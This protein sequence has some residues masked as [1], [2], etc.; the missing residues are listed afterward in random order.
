MKKRAIL[1][2]LP[3]ILFFATYGAVQWKRELVWRQ[4]WS[5]EVSYGDFCY[6]FHFT[7]DSKEI[8]YFYSISRPMQLPLES[9]LECFDAQDLGIHRSRDTSEMENPKLFL[10]EGKGIIATPVGKDTLLRDDRGNKVQLIGS[11]SGGA[12][13]P[14][15]KFLTVVGKVNDNDIDLYQVASAKW[16]RTLHHKEGI[17][18]WEFSPDSSLLAVLTENH[19]TMWNIQ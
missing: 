4:P 13:S 15:G 17:H 11:F 1:I 12:F 16:I 9:D 14:D 6:F 19:I 8:C 3:I 10:P 7:K 2:G 18:N 5:V